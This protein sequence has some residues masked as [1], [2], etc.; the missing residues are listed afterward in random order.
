MD[1]YRIYR[2]LGMVLLQHCPEELLYVQGHR[3]TLRSRIS[4]ELSPQDKTKQKRSRNSQ[5]WSIGNLL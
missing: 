1:V 4:D 2:P 3:R 5:F